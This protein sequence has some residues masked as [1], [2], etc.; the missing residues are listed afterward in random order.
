MIGYYKKM[1]FKGDLLLTDPLYIIKHDSKNDW[2]LLLSEGYDHAAL[3]LLGI[4]EYLSDEF[5]ED[6]RRNVIDN[7]GT[8]I[9]SFC[10]DS[11]LF[12]VCDLNQALSYNPEFLVSYE[13]YC[14]CL[15]RDF[16]GY[17]YIVEDGKNNKHIIGIGN[18]GFKT[19]LP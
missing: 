19:E 11:A 5:C 9:G 10:S 13:S 2:D 1:K 17:I 8:I 18:N 15:V 7:S 14:F 12:C 16:N 6:S 3:H 4:T